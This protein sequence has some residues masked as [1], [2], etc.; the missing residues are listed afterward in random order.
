[1]FEERLKT[2][3]ANFTL[4]PLALLA[5]CFAL[6]IAAANFLDLNW[7]I[8]FAAC[9][10]FAV[11]AAVFLKKS[12]A[13]IFLSAAFAAA[14]ALYFSA[15]N[16]P[17]AANRLK[18]LYDEGQIKSG[19]PIE[20]EGVLQSKPELAVG[21]FFLEIKTTRAIYKTAEFAVSGKIRLFAASENEA[22]AGEYERLN[23]QSGAI[24]RAACRL[25]REDNFLNAGVASQTEILDQS[26]IDA[27]GILKSPLLVEKIA[28]AP[29]FP[30]LGWI[31]DWRDNLLN[32]FKNNFSVST[33]GVLIASLLGDKYFLDKQTA[34]VFREGGTFHVLVISGL[35]ITFIG[36]LAFVFVR[37]FT[38][39]RLPRF[40]IVC[41]FLWAYALAVG[42]NV[43]VVRA[44]LMFTILLFSEVIYRRGTL[45]N[46]LGACALILLVW[47]PD[48]LFS[49]S[50]QLTFVSVAALVAVAFPLLEKL[51]AVG[52]W[53]LS[54]ETP[55]PPN[56]PLWLKRFCE[57]LYWREAAWRIESGR[58]VWSANF[59]KSSFVDW[60]ER[61]DLQQKILRYVFEAILVSA[62]VQICL[63]PLMI[64]YFHR[65]SFAGIFLNLWVG[66][67]IAFES[68]AAIIAVFL[69]RINSAL[70]FP[71]IKVTE[72]LNWL[73]VAVPRLFTENGWASFRVP[74]YSGALRAIY[75]LYFL[76]VLI[77][78]V[79][80]YRWNPF[81]LTKSES[82]FE[83]EEEKRKT[84]NEKWFWEKFDFSFKNSFLVKS[85]L[86]IFAVLFALIVFHPASAPAPDGRLRVDF[87][88][89]G[90]GDS[91]LITFPGG[92]TMLVDGGGKR[93]AAQMIKP[94]GGEN[95]EPEIF[96][97]DRQ[98]IGEMVVS[99][100]LWSKG[101]DAVD[102]I[103]ATHADADHIQG[104]G[105]AAKNFSVSAAVFGRTP[106]KNQE[107]AAVYNVL[108]K[109]GVPILTVARGDVLTFG[110]VKI[111]VLSPEKSDAAD[112]PSDNNHSIVLRLN[113]GARKILLTGDIEKETEREL[114]N[115]PAFVQTDVIK[116]AHHGSL[117]S[118]TEEFVSAAGAKL[119]VISV[120]RESP[121]GH[122]RAEIIERWKQSGAQ[123]MTTGENGTISISTDG[124]DLR[125]ETF[126]KEKVYR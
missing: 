105:D 3:P 126:R 54:A 10:I 32:D 96:E 46:S 24:F 30:T 72:F 74:H 51:H 66:I 97:P 1:M 76:P 79:L 47:R 40:L 68:F 89:V 6:G 55:A 2:S 43:P 85:A 71:F 110:E 107:F 42:A 112:A 81:E 38:P 88:D 119:A 117:T 57:T 98:S 59:F 69:A 94:D 104:L 52:D 11:A 49:Q 33:A 78:A 124:Q 63:L 102:C 16:Q 18:K 7:Q 87:L 91:A 109:R 44:A 39:R 118:S 121:F 36:G 62:I 17:L 92:E 8:Y 75:F 120:G 114:L 122:P 84:E 77:F 70:A 25:K 15:A 125:L 4:Y 64:I 90:Q 53:R 14:G 67:V 80:L 86:V 99:R 113:F 31:Y 50:F 116:V 60:L 61:S 83:M 106:L 29:D 123:V 20:I 21:G 108:Q 73:L 13:L 82:S 103:L 41:A 5:A 23:L 100:F 27:I 19:D 9:L 26:E 65:V 34:E 93:G 58:N 101:Y 95:D 115:A 12:F 45:L 56:V 111:E 48:D 35:H 22:F 28:D 37:L